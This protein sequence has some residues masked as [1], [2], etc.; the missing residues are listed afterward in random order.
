MNTATNW[1][2]HGA[3]IFWG[4]ISPC[5]HMVQFYEDDATFLD[6]LEGFVSG[7]LKAGEAVVIIA[8]VVHRQSLEYRLRANGVNLTSARLAGQYFALDAEESLSKFMVD[9]WPDENLFKQFVNSLLARAR[10][11][12]DRRV[13][14]FGEMV[15]LLWARGHNGATVRLEHLWHQFC[16][17]SALSLF[18]AYP[19]TGFTQDADAS[20]RE[21]CAAHSKVI[22]A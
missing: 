16:G 3:E 15:A 7:G 6:C 20:I 19:R 17:N 11:K 1:R 4:E 12:N 8:T 9:G 22:A 10:G 5:E 14:G 13:R 18:C 2:K 21:I